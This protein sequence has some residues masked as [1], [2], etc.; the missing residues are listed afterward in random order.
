MSLGI[1]LDRLNE[2]VSGKAERTELEELQEEI[3]KRGV[4]IGSIDYFAIA[5]PPAGYLKANGAVVSRTTYPDLFSAIGTT[6]G[7]GDGN[8]TFCLP[9]LMER[10]AQGSET[11]GTVK[12]AGLP[13]L[14][15][16]I[17]FHGDDASVIYDMD[18][19]FDAG[20]NLSGYRAASVL[21]GSTSHHMVNFS[22]SGSNPVYGAAAGIQPPALTLLPCIKAFDA[23]TSPGLIDVAQLVQKVSGKLDKNVNGVPVKYLAGTCDDRTNWYRKWSDGWVE[24]GGKADLQSTGKVVLSFPVPMPVR[25][26]ILVSLAAQNGGGAVPIVSGSV[27]NA[28]TAHL[29]ATNYSGGT[30]T[31]NG[32]ACGL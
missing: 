14:N 32:Y 23:M 26:R 8:T 30:A 28:T 11:P 21:P 29:Y 1:D 17:T 27:V 31:V 24:Q 7:E 15:G 19:V 4:P 13:D 6:F 20:D 5:T 16:T 22:A 9:D 18:G 25:G 10:F 3:G 12:A 2:R